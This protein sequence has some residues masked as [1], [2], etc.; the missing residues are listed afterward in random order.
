MCF[1]PFPIMPITSTDSYRMFFSYI[2]LV[3]QFKF[4]IS[5]TKKLP[6]LDYC[7]NYC[8]ILLLLSLKEFSYLF[9][10]AHELANI[11]QSSEGET[12]FDYCEG[13]Q[14]LG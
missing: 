2:S 12:L 6:L 5:F 7:Q 4:L 11:H 13:K 1:V 3:L 8:S 14:D 10:T 9:L